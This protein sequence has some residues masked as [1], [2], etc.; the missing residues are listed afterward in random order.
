LCVI[1]NPNRAT[2]QQSTDGQKLDNPPHIAAHLQAAQSHRTEPSLQK[3][4]NFA[5]AP[6]PTHHPEIEKKLRQKTLLKTLVI[7][8]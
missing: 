1:C 4:C 2:V 5:N 6:K 3:S 7:E 8:S